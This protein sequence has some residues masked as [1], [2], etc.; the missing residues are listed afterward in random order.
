MKKV[1]ED[2]ENGGLIGGKGEA[3][4][5]EMVQKMPLQFEAGELF[6]P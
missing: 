2:L 3:F 4:S 1:L 6:C 5:W